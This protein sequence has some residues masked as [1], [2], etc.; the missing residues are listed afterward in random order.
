MSTRV[1]MALVPRDGLFVKDGRGWQTSSA[2]RGYGLEWPWPSTILGALRTAWGREEEARAGIAFDRRG[3]L[4]QAANVHLSATLVL[5][6]PLGTRW[7]PE[8][9]VWPAPADAFAAQGEHGFQRLAPRPPDVATLGRDDDEPREALWVAAPSQAAKPRTG[10]RWWSERQFAAWLAGDRPLEGGF[11]LQRRIQTHVGIRPETQT[12]DDGILFSHDVVETLQGDAEWAIGVEAN[13]A[14]ERAP[15]LA[16]VGSDGRLARFETLDARLFQC[17]QEVPA[18]FARGSRGLRV[19]VVT[20]ASFQRGW[21]PDG[22]EPIGREIRGCIASLPYEVVLRAALVGRPVPI[23]GWD[24]VA[25]RPKPGARMVAPGAVY[26]FQRRDGRA[27]GEGDARA[28]W[29]SAL[30]ART[31]EGFG[32]VVPGFWNP[33]GA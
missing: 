30:G 14:R 3:W 1:R 25:G 18:A 16:T 11:S 22:L 33:M 6:R 21:L 27:F 12:A 4:A 31:D 19:V 24:M 10:P 9:R 26:F 23:S 15:S 2:G 17:A 28:L 5:R 20:P 13:V 29:L 32:R 8:H 7:E